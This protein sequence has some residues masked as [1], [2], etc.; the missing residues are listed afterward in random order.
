MFIILVYISTFWYKFWYFVFFTFRYRFLQYF[1][2]YTILYRIFRKSNY[3]HSTIL[4]NP[5]SILPRIIL[6]YKETKIFTSRKAQASRSQISTRINSIVSKSGICIIGTVDSSF[7]GFLIVLNFHRFAMCK[8]CSQQNDGKNL[9]QKQH[10]S[11]CFN[12]K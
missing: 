10:K 4:S 3:I 12:P 11:K 2:D 8:S 1:G 5:Q 9:F 7:F 6:F